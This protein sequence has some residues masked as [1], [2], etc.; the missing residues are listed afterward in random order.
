[1]KNIQNKKARF[2]YEILDKFEAGIVLTGCEVKS[3]RKGNANI[4]DSF[5][6]F[7][8]GEL[9]LINSHISEYE[10]GNIFNH[11]PT[12]PRKLLLHKDELKKLLGKVM[13]K[14]LTLVP[15]QL[16]FNSRNRAKV[17]LALGRGKKLFD[18]R[19]TIKKRDTDRETQR[20]MKS[21]R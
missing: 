2:N 7:I 17:E 5:A 14:S 18:K 13:E 4:N 16:Y 15:L 11:N 8:K 20:E 21:G 9:Y 6:R 19:E 1:V 12:Q 3:V 10:Q